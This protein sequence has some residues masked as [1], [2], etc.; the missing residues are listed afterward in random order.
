M[1]KFFL[2]LQPS[3]WIAI[4]SLSVSIAALI[5]S[6]RRYSFDTRLIGVKKLTEIRSLFF[7]YV[8]NIHEFQHNLDKWE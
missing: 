5:I 4:A 2:E 7:D 3:T 1:I 8:R 6:N